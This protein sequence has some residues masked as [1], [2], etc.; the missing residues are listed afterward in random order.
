M[1]FNKNEDLSDFG[2]RTKSNDRI[3]YYN[4]LH[5]QKYT[6]DNYWKE[7]IHSCACNKFPRGIKYDHAKNTLYVRY[8]FSGK[9]QNEIIILPSCSTNKENAVSEIVGKKIY[10]ILMHIFKDLLNLRSDNDIKINKNIIEDMRKQNEVDMDCS[11]KKLK[12]RSV[13]NYILM[14]Y[15]ITQVE[16]FNLD[17]GKAKILYRLIQLGFQFKQ[18]SS[19]DVNYEKGQIIEIQGI[20]FDEENNFF[21]LTGAMQKLTS[22]SDNNIKSNKVITVEKSIDKWVKNYKQHYNLLESM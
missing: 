20:E 18:L 5:C 15:A 2:V 11:W 21:V 14:N 1:A 10:K 12:P 7:I 4:I 9:P 13:K 6:S 17:P 8:E 16:L 19:D 22:G 3:L